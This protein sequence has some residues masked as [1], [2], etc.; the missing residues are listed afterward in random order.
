ML[1]RKI[2]WNATEVRLVCNSSGFSNSFFL[3]E[4]DDGLDSECGPTE[5]KDKKRL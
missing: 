2:R 5:R 3:L 4:S 1:R